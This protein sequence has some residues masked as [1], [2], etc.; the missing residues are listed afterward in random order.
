MNTPS[1]ITALLTPNGHKSAVKR[2]WGIDLATCWLPFFTA[3]NTQ[4]DTAI[5]ADAMGCPM[6]LGYS[7]DGSVK[8]SKTGRPVTKVVKDIADNV[9]MVK[10]NFTAGLLAYAEQV[11]GDNPEGYSA[12]VEAS[13]IAGEPIMLKDS[14]NL[15][16]AYEKRQAEALAEAKRE[17]EAI[18]PS[19]RQTKAEREAEAEAEKAKAE[20]ELVTA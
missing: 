18:A 17:A 1:Y 9:R 14:N 13:R 20:A 10:E 2:V 15:S 5:P 11:Q 12:Q 6:R 3:T 4:G 19:H 7:A 8:F 16:E